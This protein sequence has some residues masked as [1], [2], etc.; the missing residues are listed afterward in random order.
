MTTKVVPGMLIAT[1][2]VEAHTTESAARI[3]KALRDAIAKRGNASLALSGSTTPQA[4]YARLAA[5]GRLDW[6]KVKV[7]WVDERAVPPDHARSN[8]RA[9]RTSLLEPARVPTENVFR[10]EGEASDLDAAAVAYEELL[11]RHV[12]GES[13]DVMVM[14]VGDDGHTASLFPH[15]TALHERERLVVAVPPNAERDARLTLTPR[16]IEHAR[17]VFVLAL[18]A[19]KT[20]PLERI[21]EIDGDVEATPARLLRATRG[22]ITWV[23]DRAAGGLG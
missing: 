15:E 17:H 11:R 6:G 2:D 13:L 18:G 21:W 8:Y 5:D 7:F 9:A 14:G 22:T 16:M 23:I 20:A 10:M 3:G 4:T 19:A 1:P 12:P